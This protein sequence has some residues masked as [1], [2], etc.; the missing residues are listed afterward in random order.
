MDYEMEKEIRQQPDVL[1]NL[2]KKYITKTNGIKFNLPDGVKKL[3]FIA[4]GCKHG[5]NSEEYQ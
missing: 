5:R 2:I 4:S 3:V 1:R